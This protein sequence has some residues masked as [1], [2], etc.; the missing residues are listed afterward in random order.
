EVPGAAV[1]DRHRRVLLQQQQRHGLADGVAAAD[2]HRV[3]A[4][5]LDSGALDQPHAA[6][7]RA[8][9]KARDTGDEAAG[10]LDREAVDVLRRRDRLDD[11]SRRDVLG[12]GL[13]DEDAVHG[14]VGVQRRDAREQLAFAE[15]G[16]V[17]LLQRADA[18]LGA[19]AHLVAHVDLARRIFADEDHRETRCRAGGGE[20]G[21]A[22]REPGTQLACDPRA[23]DQLRQALLWAPSA[24]FS[25]SATVFA[26]SFS[27]M[28]AR[29][30]STVLMLMPR[31][32][33]ICLLSRP[34]TMRS[35]TCAS[36]VVRRDSSA[37][38]L[39][40]SWCFEKSRRAR[41][42]I[43]STRATSSSSLKGFSMKSSAPF[44]IVVTAIG[45]SPWPVMNVTG[46]GERRSSS[47]S[48]S[49]RPLMPS[50]RMS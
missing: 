13:L 27:M 36:R 50:M 2:H 1:A 48:C 29:C 15:R 12:Q 21:D 40:A 18:D 32:S 7:R 45:T 25:R 31:S 23:V 34:A 20:G 6:P 10:A 11:A 8:R 35:R 4:A 37:S 44:F 5:Q 41:S 39:A 16:G 46:S 17:G 9:P 43:F 38:R 14:G 19:G 3:L 26:F 28:L 22:L 33:A 42:S 49:S 30:A 24:I 47:L